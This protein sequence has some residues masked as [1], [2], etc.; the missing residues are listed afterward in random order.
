[1]HRSRLKYHKLNFGNPSQ[2][3]E[4][5]GKQFAIYPYHLEMTDLN[6]AA[7]AT[8]NSYLVCT[9]PDMG[10]TWKFLDGMGIESDRN[11]LIEILPHFPAEL[12]LPK[13]GALLLLPGET[14]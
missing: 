7:G 8:K 4:A 11:R 14:P 3:F 1:M 10:V 5:G 13:V 2:I 6:G 12:T 9:S